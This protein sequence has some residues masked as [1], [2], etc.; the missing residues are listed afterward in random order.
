MSQQDIVYFI[1]THF[2]EKGVFNTI[3]SR[4]SEWAIRLGVESLKHDKD[5]LFMLQNGEDTAP[6]W[7]SCQSYGFGPVPVQQQ[8][9]QQ[10][11]GRGGR[12]GQ[13]S[14]NQDPAPQTPGHQ[15]M[16]RILAHLLSSTYLNGLIPAAMELLEKFLSTD[17]RPVR[18]AWNNDA[19]WEVNFSLLRAAGK[20]A[21]ETLQAGMDVLITRLQASLPG[22]ANVQRDPYSPLFVALDQGS[23]SLSILHALR[24][25]LSEDVFPYA[26][27]PGGEFNRKIIHPLDQVLFR[28]QDHLE[29]LGRPE[30]PMD[31]PMAS[32]SASSS[33]VIVEDSPRGTT[34]FW[35][36]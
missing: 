8:P 11:G 12:G 32:A 23:S 31:E 33:A 34:R 10:R 7:R 28:I 35:R 15:E 21:F 13:Q 9:Q 30:P 22:G 5:T 19:R 36:K 27:I 3:N 6:W 24:K 25:A 18:Q 1:E 14:E 16:E 29:D 17:H 20:P 2:I 26:Y 4:I